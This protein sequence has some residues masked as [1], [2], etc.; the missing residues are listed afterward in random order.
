MKLKR[1]TWQTSIEGGLAL[2]HSRIGQHWPGT[3]RLVQTA[4]C[5][6][7]KVGHSVRVQVNSGG[8][9]QMHSSQGSEESVTL[10]PK[11]KVT[12]PSLHCFKGL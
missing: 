6:S 2:T 8:V 7:G 5:I 12:F 10:S 11:L 4:P 9:V 1:I 3:F